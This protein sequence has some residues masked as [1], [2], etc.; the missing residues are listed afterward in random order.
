MEKIGAGDASESAKAVIG[1]RSTCPWAS[2]IWSA[3]HGKEVHDLSVDL[4]Q[5]LS[6]GRGAL[7][8]ALSQSTG[9]WNGSYGKLCLSLET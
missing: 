2:S 6:A 9:V 8:R 7:D 5:P 4:R 1:E 3:V